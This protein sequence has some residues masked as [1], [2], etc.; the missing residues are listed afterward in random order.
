MASRRR[1]AGQLSLFNR[2][3]WAVCVRVNVALQRLVQSGGMA[4]GLGGSG[5]VVFAL[6]R[7][8]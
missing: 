1:V 5:G 8:R 2:K 3:P 7:L 4:R 6:S